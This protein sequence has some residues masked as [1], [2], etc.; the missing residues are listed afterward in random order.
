MLS[1]NKCIWL[2]INLLLASLMVLLIPY[3]GHT[4]DMTKE[5]LEAVKSGNV[6]S[7]EALISK[8]ADVNSIDSRGNT[9]L[10][11]AARFGHIDINSPQIIPGF[12]QKL[13]SCGTTTANHQ[14]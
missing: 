14:A 8:G 10:N 3:L 12:Q 2:F 4:D 1:D 11:M 9:P 13:S 7:L 5:L 6:N